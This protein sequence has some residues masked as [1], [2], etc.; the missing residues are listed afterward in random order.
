MKK[1]LILSILLVCSITTFA[2][3]TKAASNTGTALAPPTLTAGIKGKATPSPISAADLA[4][5]NEVVVSYTSNGKVMYAVVTKMTVSLPGTR[6][7]TQIP[8]TSGVFTADTKTAIAAQQPGAIIV[9]DGI[10]AKLPNGSEVSVKGL[11]LT[12]Q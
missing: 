2:Q 4:A 7:V 9:I 12:I 5:A 10:S 11:N 3:T 6:G 1:L 8:H